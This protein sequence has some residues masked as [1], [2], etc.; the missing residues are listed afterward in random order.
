MTASVRFPLDYASAPSWRHPAGLPDDLKVER[1]LVV[2]VLNVTPDSFSDGGT[3]NSFD[4]AIEHAKLLTRQGA[5]I[6]DVGGESTRPGGSRVS[7]DEELSRTIDV[8]R[9]LSERGIPVSIDTMRATVAREA[10]NAGALIVNDVAGGLADDAMLP[11]VATLR[12]QLGT[13][14]VYAAMHWRAHSDAAVK[15]AVY[16]SVGADV[17]RELGA[18][19]DAAVASGIAPEYLVADPGFGFSKTGDDNWDLF[20]Q[21]GPT[22]DL[23]YPLLI[24]VSRKRFLAS[25]DVD[26]DAATAAVSGLCQARRAWAVRVHDVP[27][28]LANIRVMQRLMAGPQGRGMGLGANVSDREYGATRS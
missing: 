4:A 14:A 22:E 2:G 1:T 17:A 12:T 13:P 28:T 27:T 19:L 7:E 25:L 5:D 9:A 15:A 18:R 21:L 26:R 16:D 10:V 20:D 11:T 6:V 24:G 23:G 3:H 8:V